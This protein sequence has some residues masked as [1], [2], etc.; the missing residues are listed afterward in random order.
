MST[1]TLSPS[2]T[3]DERPA[4][5]PVTTRRAPRPAES[6]VRLTRRGRTLV[7]LVAL[8]SVLMAG[9][10]LGAGSVATQERG[11]PAPTSV[12]M[13]APGET[14]WDIASRLTPTGEDVRDTMYDIKRLNALDTSALDAGQRLRVPAAE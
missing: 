3:F 12:V 8:V 10:F 5:R 6:Q 9:F 14:L 2:R 13:V 7:F 1:M 4:R 11:E